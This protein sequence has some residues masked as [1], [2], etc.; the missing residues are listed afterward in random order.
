MRDLLKGHSYLD[1]LL[2]FVPGTFVAEYFARQNP[3]APWFHVA[4]FASACLGIIP[5]AGLMGKATEHLADK[6]G[7]GVGGFLNATFGNACE[8]IIAFAAMRAGLYDIVKASITGSIIGNIL[9]VLGASV[10]AG[11]LKYDIQYFNRTA[12]A[13]SATLLA[14]GAISLT[15]P[16]TF[17]FAHPRSVD[18]EDDLALGIAVVLF[19]TYLCS[20][21]FSLKTHKHL[22]SRDVDDDARDAIGVTTWSVKK[23]M[24]ILGIATTLVAVISEMLVGSVEHTGQQLHMSQVF[25][26]VILVAIIGNAAEHSTAILMAMKNKMDLALNIALGSGA[27][28]ALFVAPLLVFLSFFF[29][30]IDPVTHRHIAMNLNFTPFEVLSVVVS[31]IILSYVAT[32]GESNWLEGVQLLAVY[33]ILGTAF[34]FATDPAADSAVGVPR[35][36]VRP[37]AHGST[38]QAPLPGHTLHPHHGASHVP[39]TSPAH[40]HAVPM[41]PANH[42]ASGGSELHG[43][44]AGAG[45]TP[46][47]TS[48]PASER[49][50]GH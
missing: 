14:L 11:G 19:I 8:L 1:L 34:F 22:Y 10:L 47:A 24:T 31:V 33:A 12:A 48:A 5:L 35:G 2:V 7:A 23:S 38:H 13:T 26:G 41:K 39:A 18:F 36:T 6:V 49:A 37:G 9:L 27:Q 20:L 50:P 44:A 29:G 43:A 28:I 21:W 32:D 25:I 46:A 30:P 15:V 40:H 42:G 45:T 17:H 3:E 4:V 16:A